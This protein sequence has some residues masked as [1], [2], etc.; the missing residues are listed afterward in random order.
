[1][2][3]CWRIFLTRS[4]ATAVV[5]VLGESSYSTA[6]LVEINL[7]SAN[8]Y[9]S[10]YY[11]KL[12]L[13]GNEYSPA[14][15]L[16]GF[17]GIEEVARM[18]NNQVTISLSAVDQTYISLFLSNEYIDR[19]IKIYR[20][21]IDSNGDIV[22]NKE[23]L[24]DGRIDQPVIQSDPNNSTSTVSLQCSSHWIDFERTNPRRYSHEEQSFRYSADKGLEFVSELPQELLW[25]KS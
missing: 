23:T 21:W 12:I 25:G 19:P 13:S 5:S 10:D 14:G 8:Y 18:E 15:H 1:M 9:L 16:L 17:S 11:R 7:D 24:F 2:S 20:V 22:N 4:Y 6:N 3:L